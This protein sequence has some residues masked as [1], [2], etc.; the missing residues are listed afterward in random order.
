[1]KGREDVVIDVVAAVETEQPEAPSAGS[2]GVVRDKTAC[3]NGE[4][5]GGDGAATEVEG[6]QAVKKAD[7]GDGVVA[8]MDAVWEG[9]EG[10][11]GEVGRVWYFLEEGEGGMSEGEVELVEMGGEGVD[12]LGE[13]CPE[14]R[15]A[16]VGER[17]EESGGRGDAVGEAGELV[18]DA[19]EDGD[20]EE[21]EGGDG[22]G[23]AI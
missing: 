5:I 21:G 22:H 1:M 8:Q 4:G 14:T 7:A 18:G 3:E 16:R 10:D 15:V 19:G 6:K 12:E 20:A 2:G 9:E 23:A 11:E 13:G 17:V